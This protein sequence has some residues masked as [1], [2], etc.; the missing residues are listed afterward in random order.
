MMVVRDAVL[1]VVFGKWICNVEKM[2][3]IRS[4]NAIF[5]TLTMNVPLVVQVLFAASDTQARRSFSSRGARARAVHCA[6]FFAL[7]P[8]GGAVPSCP[9]S[10]PLASH[11][12]KPSP[13][14][15]NRPTQPTNAPV[16]PSVDP[17]CCVARDRCRGLLA[18]RGRQ[19]QEDARGI[20]FGC[21]VRARVLL[22]CV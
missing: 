7:I 14:A 16:P 22:V 6:P 11:P 15:T 19:A 10:A 12:T 2:S 21:C 13:K 8:D 17:L 1:G 9:P 4:K 3:L 18:E 20:C 5:E